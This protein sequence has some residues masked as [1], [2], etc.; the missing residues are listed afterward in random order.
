MAYEIWMSQ[1]T[2]IHL[3]LVKK[4]LSYTATW[5]YGTSSEP[6][7]LATTSHGQTL[8]IY[9]YRK[10]QAMQRQLNI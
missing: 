7:Q 6:K 5:Q 3:L 2:Y 9:A 1:H 8:L 10:G 4:K